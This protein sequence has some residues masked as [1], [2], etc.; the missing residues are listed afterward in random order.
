MPCATEGGAS[1]TCGTPSKSVSQ[2]DEHEQHPQAKVVVAHYPLGS[3]ER[4]LLEERLRAVK[5]CER[6]QLLQEYNLKECTFQPRVGNNSRV[7]FALSREALVS[8]GSKQEAQREGQLPVF[9]RLARRGKEREV[10]LAQIA[11]EKKQREEEALRHSF[12]PSVNGFVG[13]TNSSAAQVVSIPVEERLLNYGR[14]V[15]ENRRLLQ[16]QRE[17]KELEEIQQN[18]MQHRV[19]NS[20]LREK[21]KGDIADRSKQLLIER[22]IQ[23]V[24]A[25]DALLKK[26]TFKP[27]VC[28]TSDAIDRGLKAKRDI[29]DR[30]VALYN[31]GMRQQEQRQTEAAQREKKE[32]KDMYKPFTNPLTDDWINHGQHRALFKKDFVKRQEI[33][34]RVREEHKRSLASALEKSERADVPRVNQEMI[35]QQV[36]RLY[37]RAQAIKE[38]TKKRTEEHIKSKECPFRPQLAPGTA[39]VIAHTEREQD[40]VKRLASSAPRKPRVSHEADVDAAAKRE[41]EEEEEEENAEKDGRCSRTS[42]VVCPEKAAEFYYKQK[43]ALEEREM[44]LRLQKQRQAMAELCACTFRP[45]TRTDQYLQRR[46]KEAANETQEPVVARV[47]GVTAYLQRQAE[48]K[49]RLK[50]KE[51]KYNSLGRGLPCNGANGTVITPFNLSSGRGSHQRHQLFYDQRCRHVDPHS[52]EYDVD[53]LGG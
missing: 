14:A 5:R 24:V 6:E 39:Y 36:E 31:A 35:E 50:E 8:S 21:R 27:R 10:R 28:L 26:Y 12:R 38:E 25:Q 9:E 7:G 23:R 43:R 2:C 33:Y 48:A 51:E 19:H 29:H 41:E 17:E 42:K 40:V 3:W 52:D 18:I 46:Q 11:E 30:G 44:Q 45:Q 13:L 47:S 49:R 4:H 20:S 16:R 15:E 22:E 53:V 37:M 34:S 32:S 1:A